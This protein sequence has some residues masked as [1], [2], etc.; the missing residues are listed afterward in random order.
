[1]AV[2]GKTYSSRV[3]RAL[4]LGLVLLGL[5][6]TGAFH[7]LMDLLESA[8]AACPERCSSDEGSGQC[9]PLCPDCTCAHGARPAVPADVVSVASEPVAGDSDPVAPVLEPSLDLNVQRFFQPP[10]A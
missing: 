5:Q 8:E 1:M 10:R 6:G 9:P 7:P 3:Y 2:R 4:R